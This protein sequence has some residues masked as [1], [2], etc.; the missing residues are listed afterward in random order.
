MMKRL[1]STLACSVLLLTATCLRAAETSDELF[2]AAAERAQARTV[3]VF[4]AGIGRVKGFGTGVLVSSEGHILTAYGVYLSDNLQVVLAD[5]SRHAAKVERSDTSLQ[6]ALLKIEAPTPEFFD[7]SEPARIRSGDWVLAVSNA[8]KV[9]DGK[10]ALSVTLGIASLRTRLETKRGTQDLEYSGD[11][12]LIDFVSS[13][14]GPSG[15]PVIAL[16]GRLVVMIGRLFEAKDTNTRLNY[17]VPADALAAFL[18]NEKQPEPPTTELAG[19]PGTVGVKLFGLT[20]GSRAPAYIDRVLAGA[21]AAESG[22]R[23]DDLIVSVEGEV[24]RN[25]GDYRNL[26]AKLLAGKAVLFVVKRGQELLQI[27]ITPVAE[28]N[29]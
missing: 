17:A 28:E 15:G 24:V 23:P 19:K 21:P 20:G 26:E 9:A 13:Y 11:V 16:E 10:E 27:Q 1:A 29:E 25:I 12:L 3:K 4:G 14:A 8:F 5:G 6:L 22:L 7:L 2:A 18:R